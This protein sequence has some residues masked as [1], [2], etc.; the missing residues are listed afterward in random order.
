MHCRGS[1]RRR[2]HPSLNHKNGNIA[3]FSKTRSEETREDSAP[4]NG[5]DG[6][7]A[8]YNALQ[9]VLLQT[10]QLLEYQMW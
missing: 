3:D 2:G 9:S 1:Y 10:F 5:L 6:W 8:D 7:G 4:K